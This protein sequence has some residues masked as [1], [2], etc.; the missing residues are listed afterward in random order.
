MVILIQFCYFFFL[1]LV[2]LRYQRIIL[3]KYAC[4]KALNIVG[5]LKSWMHDQ[6]SQGHAKQHFYSCF[7]AK[8][9]GLLVFGLPMMTSQSHFSFAGDNRRRTTDTSKNYVTGI[10]SPYFLSGFPNFFIQI[11]STKQLSSIKSS[12]KKGFMRDKSLRTLLSLA[13]R[14]F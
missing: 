9:S 5:D 13:H 10:K 6:N 4:Q 2:F 3:L 7:A 12:C 14:K 1:F 8:K 11:K